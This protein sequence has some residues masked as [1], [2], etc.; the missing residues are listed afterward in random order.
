MPVKQCKGY[1]NIGKIN[2]SSEIAF[3]AV[4]SYISAE[5]NDERLKCIG[6]AHDLLVRANPDNMKSEQDL[7]KRIPKDVCGMLVEFN[8]WI[9]CQLKKIKDMK[10]KEEHISFLQE[11]G[12]GMSKYFLWMGIASKY[13]S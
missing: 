2:K 11:Y 10:T 5:T 13:F 6:N 7:P 1:E 4:F 3:E 12:W 8:T 9:R